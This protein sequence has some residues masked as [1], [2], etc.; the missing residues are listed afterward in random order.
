MPSIVVRFT[1]SMVLSKQADGAIEILFPPAFGNHNAHAGHGS[2]ADHIPL[3]HFRPGDQRHGPTDRVFGPTPLALADW[4]TTK[5][6]VSNSS[7]P[8]VSYNTDPP[9][10]PADFSTGSLSYVP[11][12]IDLYTEATEKPTKDI[13]RCNAWRL[14]GGTLKAMPPS[15]P[16]A[17]GPYCWQDSKY[18]KARSQAFT[19]T[20]E[21]V[22]SH[23]GKGP[24][25]LF[26]TLADPKQPTLLV[27]LRPDIDVEIAVVCYPAVKRATS[28]RELRHLVHMADLALNGRFPDR[29]VR[30]FCL[31]A[32]CP[33]DPLCPQ[34]R[35]GF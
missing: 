4:R 30:P 32:A 16:V 3:A 25:G 11:K 27:Q 29:E 5:V 17:S 35:V 21:Y 10:L 31:P 15:N 2:D 19:D 6:L 1:G 14:E 20:L 18:G 28:G 22:L 33:D 13:Q 8:A 23:D 7:G 9:Q 26:L 24:V 34:G 12:L